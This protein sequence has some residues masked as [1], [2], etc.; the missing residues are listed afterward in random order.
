MSIMMKYI[1][2]D[3][4]GLVIFGPHIQHSSMAMMI[5]DK[6]I[7][8]G[9]IQINDDR[10]YT[11]GDSVSLGL[12]SDPQDASLFNMWYEDRKRMDDFT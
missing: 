11:I 9:K 1:N 7:S 8:A 3:N 2:F 10:V 12:T 4:V 5:N 6:P